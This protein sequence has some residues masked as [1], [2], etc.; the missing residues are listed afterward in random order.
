MGAVAGVG[1]TLLMSVVMV[2]G[3]RSGITG[4]LPP[5]KLTK[6]AVQEI[7]GH[8]H[9]ADE[10]DP[11]TVAAHLGFGSLA[12]SLYGLVFGGIRS[13]V[14]GA[15]AGIAYGTAVWAVNYLGWMPAVGIMPRAD[16]DRRGRAVV[17]IVAHWVFGASLG[18][19]MA[20]RP[21]AG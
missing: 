13:G 3:K 17:M 10:T 1:A 21:R 18:A 4:E 12:G 5:E 19:M 7:T 15:L 11:A 6:R 14:R 16:R 20:V 8:R 2:A 9:R